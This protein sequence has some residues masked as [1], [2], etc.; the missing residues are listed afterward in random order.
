MS[1]AHVDVVHDNS[2]V[3]GRLRIRS[4]KHEVLNCVAFDC[5]IADDFITKCNRTLR[6]SKTYSRALARRETPFHVVGRQVQTCAVVLEIDLPGCS[7]LPF[8]FESL[9]RTEAV[10]S[11]ARLDQ[12]PSGGSMLVQPLRL[13]IGT[14]IPVKAESLHRFENALSAFL[15]GPLDIGVLDPKNKNSTVFPGEE[16]IE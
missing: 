1:N 2:D 11:V 10:V 8:F 13:E 6:D 5:D 16:P 9:W 15:G 14:F 12:P 3:I 7:V 4:Q